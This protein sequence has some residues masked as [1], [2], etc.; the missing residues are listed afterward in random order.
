MNNSGLID[1]TKLYLNDGFEG[2]LDFFFRIKLGMKHDRHVYKIVYEN[3]N[4]DHAKVKL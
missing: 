3:I 4:S 2:V 1:E